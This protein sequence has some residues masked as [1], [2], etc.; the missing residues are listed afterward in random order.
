MYI[1]VSVWYILFPIEESIPPIFPSG[2]FQVPVPAKSQSWSFASATP[3]SAREAPGSR[4]DRPWPSSNS[5]HFLCWNMLSSS[6]FI[7]EIHWTPFFDSWSTSR[8]NMTQQV[9]SLSLN[10]G[11]KI[12]PMVYH[13]FPSQNGTEWPPFP[14]VA[15]FKLITLKYTIPEIHKKLSMAHTLQEIHR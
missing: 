8:S 2:S 1:I 15:A 14:Y 4:S 10:L 12:K 13:K 11:P 5:G 3:R 7:Y 9:W 6:K